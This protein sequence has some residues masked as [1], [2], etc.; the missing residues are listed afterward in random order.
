[1]A[2]LAKVLTGSTLLTTS[3]Q[4]LYTS[5]ANTNTRIDKCVAVNYSG[6]AATLT[7]HII[8]SG[9]S[10]SNTNIV[11]VARSITAGSADQCSEVIS[12]DLGPGD[13]IQASV[14]ANTAINI[15]LSGRTS[16]A[17]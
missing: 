14:S 17:S 4:T 16:P 11:I 10:A 9:G 6:N 8:A 3:L 15:R 13:F 5:P 7:L 1:M 2:V 12:Q